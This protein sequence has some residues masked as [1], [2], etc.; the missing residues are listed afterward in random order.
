[1]PLEESAVLSQAAA[2][3]LDA[4]AHLTLFAKAAGYEQ[5]AL[6]AMHSLDA[7]MQ[8]PDAGQIIPAEYFKF[9]QESKLG[10]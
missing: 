6:A 9:A 4:L 3:A 5:F 8:A 1:M 2:D 10:G 7:L